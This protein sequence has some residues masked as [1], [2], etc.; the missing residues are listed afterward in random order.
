MR[1]IEL[2]SKLKRKK[3]A[4]LVLAAYLAVSVLW[5][6]YVTPDVRIDMRL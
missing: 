4:L 3:R 2:L 1:P 6:D 5:G